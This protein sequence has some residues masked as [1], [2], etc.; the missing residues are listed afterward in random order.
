MERK[1]PYDDI[2][3]GRYII[4]LIADIFIIAVITLFLLNMFCTNVTM[5]GRA[6]EPTIEDSHVVL[7][8]K[9]TYS[10]HK[11]ERM[12]VILLESP[13]SGNEVIKRIVGVPGD[14]IC[15]T[16]QEVFVNGEKVI[17]EALMSAD[18]KD[19]LEIILPSRQY[20][21]VGDN[22]DF[23]E[24]S[25]FAYFGLILEEDII[26]KVWLSYRGLTD[27]KKVK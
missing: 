13:S 10:L 25:R 20:F 14:T 19:R 6:M 9:L 3:L 16:N 27:I 1:K 11:P 22:P 7:I 26:G 18:E 17:G 12:D 15:Y 4:Y 8:N 5:T 24:D 23:S 2:G 21:V